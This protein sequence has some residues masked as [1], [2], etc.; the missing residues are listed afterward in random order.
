MNKLAKTSL[1]LA[2]VLTASVAFAGQKNSDGYIKL[3]VQY[4]SNFASYVNSWVFNS[5]VGSSLLGIKKGSLSFTNILA[6]SSG[7]QTVEVKPSEISDSFNQNKGLY[8]NYL[9]SSGMQHLTSACYNVL[10]KS[11]KDLTVMHLSVD[12]SLPQ[13]LG[14]IT[15]TLT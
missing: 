8:L 5:G 6:Q 9:D 2:A 14:Q 3:N 13:P 4:D 7:A 12:S 11:V 15:C 1:L 10:H